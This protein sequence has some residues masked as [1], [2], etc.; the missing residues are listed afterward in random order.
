MDKELGQS[1]VCQMSVRVKVVCKQYLSSDW[2]LNDVIYAG[3][4]W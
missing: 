2:Y 4:R 1:V 3:T